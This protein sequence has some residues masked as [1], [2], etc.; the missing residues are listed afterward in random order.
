MP[1]TKKTNSKRTNS[2]NSYCAQA[3]DMSKE[4]TKAQV[5]TTITT[6]TIR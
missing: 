6:T 5:K 2:H 3:E 4:K 1:E